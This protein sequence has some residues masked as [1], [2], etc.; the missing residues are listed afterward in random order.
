MHDEFISLIKALTVPL[1][2][3]DDCA[4]LNRLQK[5]W[6]HWAQRER[7]HAA[8]RIATEQQAAFDSFLDN[9]TAENEQRLPEPTMRTCSATTSW[10][11]ATSRKSRI[12]ASSKCKSAASP[13]S[14]STRRSSCR[15]TGR[16][17][18]ASSRIRVG[19]RTPCATS[20]LPPNTMKRSRQ[21]SL[22]ALY[23]NRQFS[24]RASGIMQF[25]RFSTAK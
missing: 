24:F 21:Q 25:P 8:A 13:N 12:P 6:E 11:R 15:R 5:Q 17:S 9:P 23:A 20:F 4:A 2:S 10:Q 19:S 22:L 7:Q 14:I 18:S 1:L 16:S 3:G